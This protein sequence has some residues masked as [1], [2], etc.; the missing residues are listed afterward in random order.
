MADEQG[1]TTA[2]SKKKGPRGP[3]GPPG[4]QG[5]QGP[6]GLLTGAA[7]GDLT[8]NYPNPQ[9]APG[10]VGPLET[11]SVPAAKVSTGS[12]SIP[13]SANTTIP[14]DHESFDSS[15]MHS[16][17]APGSLTAPI[18]GIYLVEA[19]VL[20]QP[21]DN[22]D[23]DP[24]LRTIV[25]TGENVNGVS[26]DRSDPLSDGTAISNASGVTE[27]FAGDEIHVDAIQTSTTSLSVSGQF[28][29]VWLG[30]LTPA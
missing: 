3:A 11:S 23:A 2:K 10:A 8:G 13:S 18:D 9:I 22:P 15:D 29:M 17:L 26:G 19:T 24:G 5:A 7:S 20:W 14:F 27:V 4:P 25:L 16:D 1:A 21:S 6:A 12:T 30:P 28:S